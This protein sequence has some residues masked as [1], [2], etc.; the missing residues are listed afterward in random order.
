MPRF[1]LLRSPSIP[2]QAECPERRE[3]RTPLG[4]DQEPARNQC[5]DLRGVS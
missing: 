1:A 3:L 2:T 5:D 4:L